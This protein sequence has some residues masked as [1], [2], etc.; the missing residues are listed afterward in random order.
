[1]KKNLML[2]AVVVLTG[3]L[4]GCNRSQSYS[5][6]TPIADK[7]VNAN[8]ATVAS[9][10]ANWTNV[11][12]TS[13]DSAGVTD[14]VETYDVDTQGYPY[15]PVGHANHRTYSERCYP[16]WHPDYNPE[17]M[18]ICHQLSNYKDDI[19][20]YRKVRYSAKRPAIV[21]ISNAP[22]STTTASSNTTKA[23]NRSSSSDNSTAVKKTG[24]PYPTKSTAST[25]YP[26]ST[27]YKSSSYPST[28]STPYRSSSYPT[29][30]STPYSSSS[31]P[32]TS[33]TPYK[34]SSSSSSTSTSRPT[35]TTRRK[36]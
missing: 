22:V 12:S 25:T 5:E 32:S 15:Y 8:S 30:S 1:M 18:G 28:S 13:A 34:S 4:F 36:P 31:Y 10:D 24:T 19:T 14:W 29:T 3:I 21:Q 9:T 17:T 27:P 2:L 16:Y 26:S 35:T 20:R 23:T 11:D 7:S 6:V 33:S